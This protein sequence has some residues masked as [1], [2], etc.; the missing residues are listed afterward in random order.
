MIGTLNGIVEILDGQS[1]IVNVSGV[2]YRVLVTG[3]VLLK[4]RGVGDKIKLFT[5]T[6]VREDALDLYGFLSLDRKSVV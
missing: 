6:H 3:N 5:Y 4:V 2:G 1:L